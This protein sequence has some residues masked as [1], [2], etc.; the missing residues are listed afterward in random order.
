MQTNFLSQ[1][2]PGR[3]VRFLLGFCLAGC[4]QSGDTGT[5]LSDAGTLSPDLAAPSL[6]T[7]SGTR[8]RTHVTDPDK[9][10]PRAVDLSGSTIEALVPSS[11]GTGFTAIAGTGNSDGSFSI[12]GVALSAPYYLHLYAPSDSPPHQYVLGSSASVDLGEYSG[13]RSGV[14]TGASGTALVWSN[15]GGLEAGGESDQLLYYSSDNGLYLYGSAPS[16]GSTSVSLKQSFA[17][18]PLLSGARGD[19]LYVLQ[20]HQTATVDGSPVLSLTRSLKLPAFDMTDAASTTISNTEASFSEPTMQSVSLDYRRSQFAALRTSS[21]P[22][23]NLNADTSHQLYVCA[24][25]GGSDFSYGF[26]TSSA[27]LLA[28]SST[29]SSDVA[30]TQI[31]YGNPFPSSYG[32]YGSVGSSVTAS[33]SIPGATSSV[34]LNIAINQ[35]ALLSELT[36]GPIVPKLGPVSD[37][38]INGQ[39]A[40]TTTAP[41][42]TQPVLSWSPP[43]LGTPTHYIVSVHQLYL[44]AGTT[45]TAQKLLAQI[46]TTQNRLVLPPGLLQSGEYYVLRVVSH[47]RRTFDLA[48]PF[49][50]SIPA[51]SAATLSTL[52]TP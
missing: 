43:Q 44:R 16:V 15:V 9:L 33:Y 1:R 32:V 23:A 26:Y 52:V 47:A 36:S 10:T 50:G 42:T 12:P 48:R 18:Q 22:A 28:Y 4:G 8:I 30:L 37:L 49:R 29:G 6:V 38:Q 13:Q 11:S 39:S 45:Q 17:N 34:K 5:E 21:A 19:A 14:V 46:H 24:I 7:V 27:D 41:V 40:Y 31:R 2:A 3:L 20:L 35:T 25:L 51:S